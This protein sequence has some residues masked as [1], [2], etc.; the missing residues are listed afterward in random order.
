MRSRTRSRYYVQCP[1]DDTVDDWP[2]DRFW[3]ELARRLPADAAACLET[4]PALE[5]SVAAFRSFVVEPMRYNR[6]FLV[7]DAAHIV[8]A[9]GAKGL[10]L[11]AADVYYLWRALCDFYRYGKSERLDSYSQ[12]CLSRV[13]KTQRFSSWYT[14]LLHPLPEH[15]G[16]DRRIQLAELDY[17]LGSRAGRTTIAENYVGLPLD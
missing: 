14:S 2:D 12:D 8:P 17:V 16:F 11:A 3:D 5:K 13:W 6:L 1:R 15:T 4:G 9:T 10:N 7:G